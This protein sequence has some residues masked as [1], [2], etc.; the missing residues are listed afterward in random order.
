[1]ARLKKTLKIAAALSMIFLHA[2]SALCLEDCRIGGRWVLLYKI[3]QAWHDLPDGELAFLCQ[4][5]VKCVR[6]DAARVRHDPE[7][8][9]LWI[10]VTKDPAPLLFYSPQSRPPSFRIKWLSRD[11]FGNTRRAASL[12][13]D[14]QIQGFVFENISGETA[15]KLM[16]MEKDISFSMEGKIQGLANGQIAL[17]RAGHLIKTCPAE[18][19]KKPVLPIVMKII[20][21]K[22]GKIMARWEAA[23]FFSP[24]PSSPGP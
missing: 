17:S 12:K 9:R 23:R 6:D 11:Y 15:R 20:D 16:D 21:R 10:D 4:E 7:K 22:T 5:R 24:A 1:M 2:Q 8:K 14:G 18:A 3:I 19:K 13:K